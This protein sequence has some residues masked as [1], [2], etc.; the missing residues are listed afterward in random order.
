M[1]G[2]DD[3]YPK[4]NF[5]TQPS[6]NGAWLA[7][8]NWGRFSGSDGGYEWI[9]YEQLLGEG[10]VCVVKK[11]PENLKAYEYD[12]LGWCNTYTYRAKSIWGANVFQAE[13]T[14]EKL[15]SVSFYTPTSNTQVDIYI[16]D[17]G[18]HF[19]M[20]TPRSGTLLA[21]KTEV[22]P[23]PGYHTVELPDIELV[24][25][26]YFSAVIKYTNL[27]PEDD[28][29]AGVP[30]EV[31][32]KGYSGNAAVY[33]FESYISDSGDD[34]DWIDGTS[35][36]ND[37]LGGVPYHANVCIKAFTI[38]PNNDYVEG[39]DTRGYK[40]IWGAV[41]EDVNPENIVINDP[42]TTPSS[43]VTFA[44][45]GTAANSTVEVYLADKTRTYEPVAKISEG[46]IDTQQ[47]KGLSGPSEWT[48]LPV[49]AT[50]FVPDFF[51]EEGRVNY[52]TYGPFLMTTDANGRLTIDVDDLKSPY[53]DKK[54]IPYGYYTVYCFS[55][56]GFPNEDP[57]SETGV[58][59]L[60]ASDDDDDSDSGSSG[61]SGD[62]GDSGSDTN[63]NSGSNPNTNTN[64]GN[65]G[66]VGGGGCNA[67]ILGAVTL[68][69]P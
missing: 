4:E 62:S 2:W 12:A 3:N 30:I 53:G 67:G 43:R 55:E 5:V 59:L 7:R 21:S 42:E 38:A 9:S 41:P 17:T 48:L 54:R 20:E 37:F 35:L 33:D 14:G 1:I 34:D 19:V 45:A 16:Y 26:H 36:T 15:H 22:M 57:Y 68:I 52:A 63:N 8:N 6:S 47:A 46:M 49:Y 11:R 56:N 58:F 29:I 13:T 64:T 25:G 27:N 28:Q 69:W 61:D 39:E 60:D 31:A 50:G 18:T 40:S 32:I 66:G 24:K 51:F 65:Y 44:P 10:A 23:Y